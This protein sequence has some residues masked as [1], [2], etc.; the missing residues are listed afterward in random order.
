MGANSVFG[1]LGG[2]LGPV[3]TLPL[4]DVVGFTPIYVTCATLPLLGGLVLLWGVRAETGAIRAP[5]SPAGDD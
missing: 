4:V 3:L 5:V 2:A 1:D